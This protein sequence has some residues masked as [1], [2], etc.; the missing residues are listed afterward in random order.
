MILLGDKM[1][2]NQ[3]ILC[4]VDTCKYNVDK[5]LCN[6]EK[7]EVKCDCKEPTCCSDT[8]CASYEKNDK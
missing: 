1:N 2:K 3:K 6:L 7:I 4:N 8:I 5:K